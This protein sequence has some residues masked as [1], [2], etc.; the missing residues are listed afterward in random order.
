MRVAE[1][2]D[3][4]LHHHHYRLKVGVL[5]Q[6]TFADLTEMIDTI[7]PLFPD[8]EVEDLKPQDFKS[9]IIVLSDRWG[10][11]RLR[12]LRHFLRGW[13]KFLSDEALIASV[14]GL[15]RFLHQEAGSAQYPG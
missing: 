4:Y 2:L 1:A 14:P 11:V 7:R 5:R 15:P 9:V 6:A 13:L 3:S 12:R 10:S 8:T